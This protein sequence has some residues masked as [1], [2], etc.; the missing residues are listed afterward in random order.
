[1]KYLFV[2][3]IIAVAILLLVGCASL[4][5][6]ESLIKLAEQPSNEYSV[7]LTKKDWVYTHF[8]FFINRKNTE[9][10][11]NT[12]NYKVAYDNRALKTK[13][14]SEYETDE[15]Y[16]LLFPAFVIHTGTVDCKTNQGEAKVVQY[17]EALKDINSRYVKAPTEVSTRLCLILVQ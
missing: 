10:K 13:T 1:M 6:T 2:A 17:N 16:E 7:A 8:G 12:L 5:P 9:V 15:V 4:T 14:A 11:G 3:C